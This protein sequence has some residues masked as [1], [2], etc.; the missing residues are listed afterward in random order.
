MSSTICD[1]DSEMTRFDV[2]T[3]TATALP[4]VVT[5]DLMIVGLL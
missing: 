2:D 3:G 5:A 1:D 4:S